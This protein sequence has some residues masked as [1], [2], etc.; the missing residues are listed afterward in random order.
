MGEVHE[1]ALVVP[2]V[3]SAN[4]GFPAH[5]HRN[6]LTNGHI[7]DDENRLSVGTGHDEAL[8]SV[9]ADLV[10]KDV[11]HRSGHRDPFLRVL[12]VRLAGLPAIVRRLRL[13]RRYGWRV[14]MKPKKQD[15]SHD[16]DDA[17][18]DHG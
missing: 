8:M 6:T 5:I 7:I 15:P 13:Y 2:D 4:S 16:S 14:L 17:E 10:G 11:C 1:A 18:R 12:V 9:G 3:D